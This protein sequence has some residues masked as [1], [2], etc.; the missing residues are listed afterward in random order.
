MLSKECCSEV[1]RCEPRQL[2]DTVED[3]LSKDYKERFRAEYYQLKIRIDKLERFLFKLRAA[4]F[5]NKPE[6]K[7]D[8]PEHVLEFQLSC[9]KQYME[10]LK[11][12]A[13]IEEVEVF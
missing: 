11:L 6:P 13:V 5:T 12:R 3:M 2:E 8:C 7:H 9:M 1:E 4:Q 10:Q